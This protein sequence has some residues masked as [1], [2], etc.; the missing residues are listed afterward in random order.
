MDMSLFEL[1]YHNDETSVKAYP[2]NVLLK[3][4]IYSYSLGIVSSRTIEKVFRTNIILKA[5][6]KDAELDHDNIATFISKNNKA[7]SDLFT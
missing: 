5:L 6:A 1:N 7:V 2:P 4:I 3:I